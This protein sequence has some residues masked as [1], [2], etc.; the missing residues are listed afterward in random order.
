[1]SLHFG[2]IDEGCYIIV[3]SDHDQRR[4]LNLR[5]EHPLKQKQVVVTLHL[6]C[7]VVD[8]GE[9]YRVACNNI[10]LKPDARQL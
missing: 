3:V 4:R 7:L 8:E 2:C 5:N 9:I 6:E 10:Y 1:M